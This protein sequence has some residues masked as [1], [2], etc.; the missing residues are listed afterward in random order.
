MDFYGF[1]VTFFLSL[2]YFEDI[3]KI[4]VQRFCFRCKSSEGKVRIGEPQKNA[5]LLGNSPHS[6]TASYQNDPQ[7]MTWCFVTSNYE[8]TLG[9]VVK[10]LFCL[11]L[12]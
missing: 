4:M 2:G 3:S 10:M 12:F 7:K 11:T 8:E 1:V 9:K 6:L 5:D